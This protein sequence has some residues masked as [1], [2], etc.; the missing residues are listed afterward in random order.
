MVKQGYCTFCASI[1][2][3]AI[4]RVLAA[5]Y[6]SAAQGDFDTW[7][8]RNGRIACVYSPSRSRDGSVLSIPQGVV[9]VPIVRTEF[10]PGL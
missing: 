3:R 7:I 4:F 5:V 8:V 10:A 9:D 6:V 1:E 2:E